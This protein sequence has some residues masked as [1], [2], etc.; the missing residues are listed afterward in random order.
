M[1]M[2]NVTTGQTEPA[3]HWE[4]ALTP[5]E[6]LKVGISKGEYQSA[7]LFARTA[8]EEHQRRRTPR[9]GWEP[10]ANLNDMLAAPFIANGEQE[11]VGRLESEADPQLD[12]SQELIGN[13]NAVLDESGEAARPITAPESGA[14]YSVP[15]AVDAV[16]R[17]NAAIG[18]DEAAGLH[19]HRR[20]SVVL[21]RLAALAPWVEAVGFLTFLT[22]YLNVPI[23]QPWQD[24]L[25]WSFA[26]TV[27]VVIIVG[28]TWLVRHAARDHNHAREAYANGHR[29]QA[30]AAFTRRNWYLALTSLTAVAITS[31]MIWRGVAA[32]GNAGFVTTAVMVFVAAVTGLLLP[33]LGYLGVALD[34]SKISRERD[35]LVADLDDDLER[36][37]STV[38]DGRRDLADAAGI[39]DTLRDKTFPDI[40]NTT[41]E[42]VDEV[43]EFYATVRLLIGA[44]ST[45]PP[46]KTAKTIHRDAAGNII[47][48]YIGTS[49]PG[50][51]TVNLDPLFDRARRLAEEERLAAALSKRIDELPPHPW[52]ASRTS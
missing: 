9:D 45:E 40:C 11:L 24:W 8:A 15:E 26:A 19:H 38:G 25:G 27:V 5:R 18:R 48:G 14:T 43:Y 23:L 29:H 47:G 3:E 17:H 44:L 41:Q 1:S 31:G 30:E 13:V 12:K 21:Q 10:T 33:T 49:I 22:Y 34:G 42:A 2:A 36:Y 28:Q 16:N 7:A 39:G 4:P 35:S 37:L 51:R 50:A 46:A 32:L 52:G 20:A 6:G